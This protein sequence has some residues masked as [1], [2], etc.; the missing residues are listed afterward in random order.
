MITT[1]VST[2]RSLAMAAVRALAAHQSTGS[3]AAEPTISDL[4]GTPCSGR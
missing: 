4:T 3:Q 2:I 1:A